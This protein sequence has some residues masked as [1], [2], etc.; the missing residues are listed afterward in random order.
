[1]GTL[2][3]LFEAVTLIQTRMIENF[4]VVIFDKEYHK[5]LIQHI[6][7]MTKSES[8]SHE[9]MKLIFT[10]DSAEEVVNHIKVHA[11][12]KFDLVKKK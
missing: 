9:D 11:I 3:E 4:P 5:E 2:D 10:T 8:I 1:M 7:L 6:E 12:D